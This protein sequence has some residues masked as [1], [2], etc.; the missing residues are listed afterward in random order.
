ME[1]L[2]AALD[3]AR[4][5]RTGEGSVPVRRQLQ[6]RP[7]AIAPEVDALWQ[8]LA[9]FEVDPRLL[10][11][12]LVVTREA[13]EAATPFDILRTK[14]LLQM[15]QNGWKRL[16]ITSP[17]PGAGKTT[18]ACNLA[19]GMGRQRDLR[20][21]LFDLDLRDPSAH[22]FFE[23]APP[24]P[25]GDV[26]T[27]KVPF[28]AQGMRYG[29]NV[30]I[31]T[32]HHPV[33]DPTRLL[34]AEETAEVLDAIEA[35]YKPDLMIFDL[36]SVLVNDDTRAFLKNVDCALIVIRAEET[37]F[38]QFDTCEREVAEH[39]NVLGVVL[40]AYRYGENTAHKSWK[41]EKA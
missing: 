27:G 41:G 15:R 12:H 18:V 22:H 30:A 1:K 11:D 39:T 32:G 29:D 2:Q 5:T 40:N 35:A 33:A 20:S 28:A 13:G 36:P 6:T 31:S 7:Q 16:A 8:D 24:Y 26:L 23:T 37:R 25:I 17:M 9:S 10:V 4:K 21:M 34:L 3:K 38:G 19:L 14:T